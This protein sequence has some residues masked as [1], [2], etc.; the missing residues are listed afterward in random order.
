[1]SMPIGLACSGQS[2]D[3]CLNC[4]SCILCID[5][6]TRANNTDISVD[7]PCGWNV[8]SGTWEILSNE[9]RCTAAGVILSIKEHPTFHTMSVSVKAKHDTYNS[10]VEVI[11]GGVDTANYWFVRFTV[12][13]DGF[14]EIWQMSGGAPTLRDRVPYGLG[15]SIG[16]NFYNTLKACITEDGTLTAVINGFPIALIDTT[17]FGALGE[18]AGLGAHGPGIATFD[19]FDFEKTRNTAVAIEQGCTDVPCGAPPQNCPYACIGDGKA[20]YW[21]KIQ[22]SGMQNRAPARCPAQ[23]CQNINGT[24]YL[25]FAE[26][27]IW[28][29]WYTPYHDYMP[30][31]CRGAQAGFPGVDGL[32]YWLDVYLNFFGGGELWL[33]INQDGNDFISIGQHRYQHNSPFDDGKTCLTWDNLIIPWAGWTPTGSTEYSCNGQGATV[34]ITSIPF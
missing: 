14:V 24:Y 19:D 11:I 27:F 2:G 7:S 6:F 32:T 8:V 1:M 15:G 10:G 18:K 4:S 23:D 26:A 3:D 29:R 30:T 22:I 9:L 16:P 28:C 5:R 12:A 34:K 25:P 17:P 20:P 33:T 13:F 21:L 31:I